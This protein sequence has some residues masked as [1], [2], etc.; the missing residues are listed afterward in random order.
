MIM[1]M[2]LAEPRAA[3]CRPVCQHKPG[4]PGPAAWL[5]ERGVRVGR[6]PAGVRRAGNLNALRAAPRVESDSGSEAPTRS[7][8]WQ[9]AAA[10]RAG[11][12]RDAAAKKDESYIGLSPGLAPNLGLRCVSCECEILK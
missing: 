9:P 8:P 1:M 3:E 12:A 5:P 6:A 2:P 7:P 11:T 4:A 10:R